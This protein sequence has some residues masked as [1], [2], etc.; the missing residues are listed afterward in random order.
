L[1]AC[2]PPAARVSSTPSKTSRRSLRV[3]LRSALRT[4]SNCTGVAVRAAGIVAPS[5]SSPDAGVPGDRSTKKLPSRK[6]RGRIRALASSCTGRPLSR[7]A[8]VTVADCAP[9]FVCST[10]VTSP[11]STPAIRTGECAPMP[12]V[13]RKAALIS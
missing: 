4:S 2:A 8:S 10:F 7:S 1:N 6:I 13:S 12:A 5:S 9:G 3:S 11:T